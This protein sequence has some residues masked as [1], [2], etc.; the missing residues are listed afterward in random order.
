MTRDKLRLKR[1]PT[2]QSIYVKGRRFVIVGSTSRS[3]RMSQLRSSGSLRSRVFM[4]LPLC[5]SEPEG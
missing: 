5:I 1:D 2:G 3:V 4:R